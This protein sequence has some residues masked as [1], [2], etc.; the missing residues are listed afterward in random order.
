M[1]SY[2]NLLSLGKTVLFL[3]H[4]QQ[5]A[6]TRGQNASTDITNVNSVSFQNS[7]FSFLSP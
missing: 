3:W 6:N 7:E 2:G 5:V 4:I 1:D